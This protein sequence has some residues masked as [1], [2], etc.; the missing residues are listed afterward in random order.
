[1]VGN[2]YKIYKNTFIYHYVL[3]LLMEKYEVTQTTV[4]G[5]RLHNP[6]EI[7]ADSHDDA[8]KKYFQQHEDPETIRGLVVWK[9]GGEQKGYGLGDLKKMDMSD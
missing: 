3:V 9:Q 5:E 7:L 2:N 4:S 1:M 6:D 8:V